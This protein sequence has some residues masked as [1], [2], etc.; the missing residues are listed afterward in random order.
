MNILVIAPHPDDESIGCG[1]SICL[2][3]DRGNR[4]RVVFLTSGELGLR[5]LPAGDAKRIR[6]QEAERVAELLG[7]AALSFLRFP[8]G[9]L[10]TCISQAAQALRP[11]LE[12]EMPRL[13]YLPHEY[14]SHP[15][16]NIATSIVRA[17]LVEN[18]AIM[19]SLLGYEV[20]TPLYH[21]N[22]VVDITAAMSRKLRAIR[23]Y[24][25]QIMQHRYDRMSLELNRYRGHFA[26]RNNYAEAFY[27]SATNLLY[28]SAA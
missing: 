10:N 8:D 11:I 24:R 28:A 5:G 25:S 23:R 12:H 22:Y 20:W 21:Y 1:G 3:T 7:V 17:A 6:E 18:R 15:D 19:P 14:D 16:H 27:Y 13:I 4:V 26:F 9:Y 2:H